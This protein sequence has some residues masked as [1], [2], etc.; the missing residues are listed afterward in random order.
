MFKKNGFLLKS[1]YGKAAHAVGRI[2]L[3]KFLGVPKGKL[4]LHTITGY[5][6]R[7][8]VN[9]IYEFVKAP[10]LH[11]RVHKYISFKNLGIKQ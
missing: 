7:N 4:L 6:V 5:P 10:E 2:N 8:G 9:I 3:G 11:P 1:E